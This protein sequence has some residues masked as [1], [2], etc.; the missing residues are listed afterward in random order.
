[1]TDVRAGSRATK[2]V[3]DEIGGLYA[4]LAVRLRQIVGSQVQGVP[5]PVIEDAC[6]VAWSRLI[7]YQGSVQ[8]DRALGWLATTASREAIRMRAPPVP[9]ALPGPARRGAVFPG[10]HGRR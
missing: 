9:R 7:R 3:S 10:R 1:M 5:D 6:Q 8:R 4:A 2:A